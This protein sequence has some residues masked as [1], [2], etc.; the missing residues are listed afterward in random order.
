MYICICGPRKKIDE[1]I[2]KRHQ[3]AAAKAHDALERQ[4]DINGGS[5]GVYQ[6]PKTMRKVGGAAAAR[7]LQDRFVTMQVGVRVYQSLEHP[8][9]NSTD[10]E[11][12]G[13]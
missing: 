11:R 1:G 6:P 3:V 4:R 8:H 9:N 7:A 2:Q 5:G 12:N 13:Y 10:S